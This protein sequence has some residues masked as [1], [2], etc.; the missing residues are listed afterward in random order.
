MIVRI[1]I[2]LTLMAVW[3]AGCASSATAPDLGGIYSRAAAGSEDQR[4][5]VIVIP[6]IL[7]SRLVEKD[8]GRVVWGAFA[9]DFADPAD[10]QGARLIA[11]PMGLGVPLYALRDDV[12]SDGALDRVKVNVLILS[13]QIGAYVD[14]L[15][16]LGVGGYRDEQLGKSGAVDYGDNHYTCFQFDYDWRRDIVENARRFDQFVEQSAA[17]V[18]SIR[19]SNQPIRFDVVAHSMGGLLARY[20]LQYGSSDL[21]ADGSVP[22]PTWRGAA[23]LENIVLVGTPN[24]GSASALINLVNGVEIGPFLPT[25]QAGLLGTMPA[26][27][28]L[29][30]RDR[31]RCV[32][33][34]ETGTPIEGLYDVELWRR[35]GWGLADPVQDKVLRVLLPE[36]TD[37]DERRRIALDHLDKCL[38]RAAQLHAALDAGSNPPD[39]VRLKLIAGDARPTDAVVGV[40]PA[41]GRVKSIRRAPGDGTVTRASALLDERLGGTWTPRLQTPIKWDGVHFLFT[42]HLGLT[43]DPAFTDNVLYILL[44]EPR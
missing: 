9:G 1:P 22:P 4:N 31:H 11:H 7:G 38:K 20:Y 35:R 10:P 33:D 39:G 43:R 14:I 42:D 27:Y 37:P 26:V 8:T 17:Y 24:G 34:A 5:P 18:R 16:T 25:Y 13:I 28:Q 12:V 21:P 2:V 15:S 6:G 30:P 40:D 29:L 19:G 32:V 3:L 23:R 36:V 44:E 41:T